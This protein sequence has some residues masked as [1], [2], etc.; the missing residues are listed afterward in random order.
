MCSGRGV[1]SQCRRAGRLD[2]PEACERE[3]AVR[4]RPIR[5]G[6]LGDGA[7]ERIRAAGARAASSG[8]GVPVDRVLLRKGERWEQ[9]CDGKVGCLHELRCFL[10]GCEGF[11]R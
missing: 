7:A 9:Q 10:L 6:G 2:G 5:G 3:A 11:P 4:S 1:H 8:D